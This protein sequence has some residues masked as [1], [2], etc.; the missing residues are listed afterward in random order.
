M[1]PCL[2]LFDRG[3]G[4]LLEDAAFDLMA[5]ATT[6]RHHSVPAI[7]LVKAVNHTG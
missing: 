3:G 2:I 6:Q 7:F 5:A 1:I 4:C